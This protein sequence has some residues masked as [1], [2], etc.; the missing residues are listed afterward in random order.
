MEILKFILTTNKRILFVVALLIT[1]CLNCTFTFSQSIT[2]RILL[3]KDTPLANSLVS[4][5]TKGKFV[6]QCKTD[7]SGFFS[8][9]AAD[10]GLYDLYINYRDHND[11]LAIAHGDTE[12]GYIIFVLGSKS[13]LIEWTTMTHCP[14]NSSY[15]FDP[16]GTRTMTRE[17]ISHLPY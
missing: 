1:L 10:T 15:N 4:A 9:N 14:I 2:G 12:K 3:C 17:Q 5:Y 8:L 13:Y 6:D 16:P 11:T 7:S